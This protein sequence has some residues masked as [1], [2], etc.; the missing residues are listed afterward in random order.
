[1]AAWYVTSGPAML[2]EAYHSSRVHWRSSHRSQER[3]ALFRIM[4]LGAYFSSIA[5]RRLLGL[6]QEHSPTYI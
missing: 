3:L 6:T 5:M 1:M 2:G 4:H